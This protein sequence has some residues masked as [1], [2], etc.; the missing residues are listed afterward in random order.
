MLSSNG[1][2]KITESKSE[3]LYACVPACVRTL[4]MLRASFLSSS[5]WGWG[6]GIFEAFELGPRFHVSLVERVACFSSSGR[7][8]LSENGFE[9]LSSGLGSK[10]L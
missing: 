1:V 4:A 2:C 3:S 10:Q 9:L 6:K 7:V 5:G 8:D